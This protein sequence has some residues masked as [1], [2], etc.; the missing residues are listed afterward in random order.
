MQVQERKRAKQ[1]EADDLRALKGPDDWLA[2]G[3]V[4]W[5]QLLPARIGNDLGQL[6]WH[7]ICRAVSPSKAAEPVCRVKQ[8]IVRPTA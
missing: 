8:G 2:S 1:A 4:A 7:C 5:Q 6:R 3:T